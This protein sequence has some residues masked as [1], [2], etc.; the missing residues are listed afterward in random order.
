[1]DITK[2]ELVPKHIILSEN[3]K[4]ELLKRYGITIRQLPRILL[5]DPVIK[6]MNVKIGD[7]IKIIRKSETAGESEYYRVVVRGEKG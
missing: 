7:V 4:E 6:T 2:H 5:S 3:E 1:M